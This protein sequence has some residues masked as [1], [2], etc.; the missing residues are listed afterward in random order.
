[1]TSKLRNALWLH[2]GY[3]HKLLTEN[4]AYCFSFTHV[5]FII[6]QG[7]STTKKTYLLREPLVQL[8][9]AGWGK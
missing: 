2:L 8:Q 3:Y 9:R 1:M 5:P 6:L 7:I 4:W